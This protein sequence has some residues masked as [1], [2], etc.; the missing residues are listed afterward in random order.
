MLSINNNEL[1]PVFLKL[2]TLNVLI[3]GGGGAGTEKLHFMMKNSPNAKVT[4]IAAEVSEEIKEIAKQHPTV[5]LFRRNF[6]EQDLNE[7]DIVIVATDD[8]ALNKDIRNKA[9]SRKILVNVA[10]TP[11]L[12]D[13]YLGS[14][15]TKGDLKIAIS[16]NGKSPTFAKRLREVLEDI[17]PDELPQLI[18]NLQQIRNNLKT[19]FT[20][21]VKQLNNITSTLVNEHK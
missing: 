11:D 2:E 13:F 15:V 18:N 8:A 4:L 10:D 1:Y 5:S 3:I 9:K 12:C 17:L 14:I 6:E 20:E 19:G 16:T 7:R 21:K